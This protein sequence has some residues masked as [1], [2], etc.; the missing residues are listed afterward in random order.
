MV[1]STFEISKDT[2][3]CHLMRFTRLTSNLSGVAHNRR[4]IGFVCNETTNGFFKRCLQIGYGIIEIILVKLYMAINRGSI[5][6]TKVHFK[7]L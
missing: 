6:V 2:F 7:S 5:G 3:G 4:N 1:N